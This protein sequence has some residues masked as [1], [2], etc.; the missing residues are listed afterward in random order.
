MTKDE[1]AAWA[2]KTGWKTVAGHPSLTKPNRPADPIVRLVLLAT[3]ANVE[4][5]K[6]AGKWEKV[7]GALYAAIEAD[8]DGGLPDGLGLDKLHALTKLIQDN[9]DAMVFAPRNLSR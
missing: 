8:P 5:R 1:L 2:L 4:I 9:R 6:P 3:V 7:S